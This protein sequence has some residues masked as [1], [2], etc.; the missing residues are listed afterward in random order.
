MNQPI[1]FLENWT[2]PDGKI[3]LAGQEFCAT[4]IS[5]MLIQG[6]CGNCRE[7]ETNIF[8]YHFTF[9]G[10]FYHV[11]WNLVAPSGY[12]VQSD[13]R[14]REQKEIE[15]QTTDAYQERTVVEGTKVKHGNFDMIA[16]VKDFYGI[17]ISAK[18]FWDQADY[19]IPRD[20]RDMIRNNS[21]PTPQTG[22]ISGSDVGAESKDTD[23][24]RV[25]PKD[26]K[27]DF[28]QDF[29]ES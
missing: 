23:F 9:D 17:D 7:V 2:A 25:L 21:Y 11:P 4:G 8:H 3:F 16:A 24:P 10:T 20:L 6:D 29:D 15:K 1:Q 22:N 26:N 19:N 13:N 28:N 12:C 14:T 5:K 18:P 27:G